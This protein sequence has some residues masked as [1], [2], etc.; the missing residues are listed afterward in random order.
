MSMYSDKHLLAVGESVTVLGRCVVLKLQK[1]HAQ[2][3]PAV[4]P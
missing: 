3:S 2:P 4:R 1:R